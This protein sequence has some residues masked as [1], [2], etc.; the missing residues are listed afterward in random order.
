MDQ[1]IRDGIIWAGAALL[2]TAIAAYVYWCRGSLAE[3]WFANFESIRL[4]GSLD[5]GDS[6][7]NAA[8]LALYLSVLLI[9]AA[10]GAKAAITNRNTPP[11]IRFIVGW[12]VVALAS[13]VGFGYYFDHYGL[14][15]VAPAALCAAPFLGDRKKRGWSSLVLA[16]ALGACLLLPH[17]HQRRRGTPEEFKAL[18]AAI[19]PFSAGGLLVWDNLPALYY[20]TNAPLP[21]R[22]PFP[23][24]LRDNNELGATGVDRDAELA[25][26][27]A[28]RPKVVVLEQG[29][30]GALLGDSTIQL[31]GHLRQEYHLFR[32]IKVGR[33]NQLVYLRN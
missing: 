24:H 8:T 18:V 6:A 28:N 31:M 15:I 10:S 3:F 21:G 23:T 14:P 9:V 5:S 30:P 1:L 16:G 32:R 17:L 27:M 13:V 2:P 19:A 4:R 29:K 7:K 26:I 25:R 33:R 11:A 20:A 12:L 22:Y